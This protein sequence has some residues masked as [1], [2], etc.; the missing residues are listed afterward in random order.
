MKIMCIQM[1]IGLLKMHHSDL[2][3]KDKILTRLL[4]VGYK[5]PTTIG[6]LIDNRMILIDVIN[7]VLEEENQPVLKSPST[8]NI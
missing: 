5:P 3:T 8:H 6:E 4:E 1:L 2:S 7:S